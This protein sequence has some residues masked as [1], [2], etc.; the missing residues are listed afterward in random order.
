MHDPMPPEALLEGYP[1]PMRQIAEQLRVIVRAAIPEAVE[2]VRPG[3][4]IIG[5]DLPIGR[6][7]AYFA[8]VAPEPGHVHLGF[9]FGTLM[10]DPEHLLQGA[11]ITKK[12]RWLTFHP[13][14][15]LDRDVLAGL[16]HEGA[17]VAGLSREERLAIAED[18]AAVAGDE[19][20]RAG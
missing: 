7:L 12:V 20:T 13:G 11:G 9:A 5:Y 16:V 6:R 2:R 10:R 3:W 15:A 1:D 14:E 8:F 17:R 19:A 4:R 18:R